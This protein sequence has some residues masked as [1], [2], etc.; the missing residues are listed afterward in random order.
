MRDGD[1][2]QD[3]ETRSGLT[4]AQRNRAAALMWPDFRQRGMRDREALCRVV[5]AVRLGEG[6][7]E[8]SRAERALLEEFLREVAG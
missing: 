5:D 8:L 4:P 1:L 3:D 2:H 6:A 7:P